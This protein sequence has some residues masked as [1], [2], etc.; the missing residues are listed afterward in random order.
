MEVF[1]DRQY[2]EDGRLI[3]RG[4]PGAVLE[5]PD[6]AVAARAVAMVCEEKVLT[7]QGTALAQ[8]GHTLCLHGDHPGAGARAQA[9]RMALQAAGVA[10]APLGSWL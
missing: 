2:G 9:I 8:V 7:A 6:A 5:L 3:P 4:Q 1:A 10:V